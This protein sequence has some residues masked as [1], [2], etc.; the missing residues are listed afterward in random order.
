KLPTGWEQADVEDRVVA[1]YA[2]MMEPPWLWRYPTQAIDVMVDWVKAVTGA[3][4]Q[5]RV[6]LRLPPSGPPMVSPGVEACA[7][8]FGSGRRRFGILTRPAGEPASQGMLLVTSTFAYRV[9]P[10]RMNVR[11]ARRLAASGI[12]T[13]RIDIGGVGDSRPVPEMSAPG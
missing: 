8:W 1:G 4:P 12:A 9:G 3:T 10:H 2:G 6:A 5:P 13:L 7:V 11:L